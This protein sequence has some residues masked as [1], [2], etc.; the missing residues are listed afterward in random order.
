MLTAGIANLNEVIAYKSNQKRKVSPIEASQKH[1]TQNKD[2]KSYEN[3]GY[4]GLPYLAEED[5]GRVWVW[6]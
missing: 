5:D 6:V 1:D 3:L 4:V 2:I